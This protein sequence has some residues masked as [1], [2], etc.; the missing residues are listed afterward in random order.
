M[1]MRHSNQAAGFILWD[2]SCWDHGLEF[3]LAG[4]GVQQF[5]DVSA[6]SKASNLPHPYAC[7]PAPESVEDLLDALLL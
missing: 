4:I 1:I 5:V 2:S 3:S 7:F 6:N